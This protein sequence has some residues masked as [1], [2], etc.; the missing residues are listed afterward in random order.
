M[1]AGLVLVTGASGFVGQHMVQSL[2]RRGYR[3]RAASRQ[4]SPAFGPAVET[5]TLPDLS[6]PFSAAELVAGT[7]AVIHLAGIAHATRAIPEAAYVA[8]N[9]TA[10]RTLAE[11]ARGAGVRRFILMSSV[12]AQ[13]GPS[14]DGI[15]TE[16]R[17]PA[18]TDA[19]G[20]SKLAA[21]RAIAHALTGS[22]V[23]WTV[24]RPV[25]VY[26]AGVKGNMQTLF[27]LARS[28]WPLPV[29]GLNGRRSIVSVEN[30]CSAAVHALTSDKTENG[31]FLVAEDEA[32]TVAEMIAALRAGLGRNAGV[33]PM[34][35]PAKAVAISLRALQRDALAARL[36]EDLI[37][38]TRHLRATGWSPPEQ[39]RAALAAALSA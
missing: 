11:A 21:E 37:V 27:H 38:D 36:L 29:G 6:Q 23:N 4:P 14:V 16:D 2:A 7:D 5:V 24:L 1:M 20:R 35:L 28:R 25:L 26:G 10:A 17:V 22:A 31:T 3:V 9:A 39:T 12:R 19:Y 15:L 32:L 30:L 18:P 33:L 34:L 13:C 8:T